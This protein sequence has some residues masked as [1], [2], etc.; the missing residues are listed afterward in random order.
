MATI[1]AQVDAGKITRIERLKG[2]SSRFIQNLQNWKKLPLDATMIEI[3]PKVN[4]PR[5]PTIKGLFGN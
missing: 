3:P 1:A 5:L 4:I 2:H